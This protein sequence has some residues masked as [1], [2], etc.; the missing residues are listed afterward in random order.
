MS[1]SPLRSMAVLGVLAIIAVMVMYLFAVKQVTD[2]AA[3]AIAKKVDAAMRRSLAKDAPAKMVAVRK[4]AGERV[5]TVYVLRVTPSEAVAADP[6]AVGR[7]MVQAVEIV[8]SE[9][10]PKKKDVVIS[11][12]VP[13][14]DG[15]E[16]RAS[17]DISGREVEDPGV[18]HALGA[19]GDAR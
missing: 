1:S 3:P 12:V 7:L 14:P 15:T 6:H 2:T 4:H 18:P 16:R 19:A 13:L 10:G 5:I 11:C 8:R 17:Y 9:L